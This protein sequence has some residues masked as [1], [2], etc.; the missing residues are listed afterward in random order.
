[1]CLVAR[2]VKSLPQFQEFIVQLLSFVQLFVTSWT[3][4]Y[5]P[6]LSFTISWSL[7]KLLFIKW[8]MLSNHLILCHPLLLLPSIF[9]IFRVLSNE[10]ALYIRWSKY[11]SFDFS[12]S[13]FN[14]YSGLR[15]FRIGCLDFKNT[16]QLKFWWEEV[17]IST[18]KTEM[19][20][21]EEEWQ[22]AFSSEPGTDNFW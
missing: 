2:N 8:V 20:T 9:P 5:Q 10:S 7:L 15:S 17:S 21:E 4:A 22:M 11:W 16:P 3:A 14:E 1:M 13:P 12:I 6:P 18:I 19:I